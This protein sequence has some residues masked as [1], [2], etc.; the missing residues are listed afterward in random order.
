MIVSRKC[1]LALLYSIS[2][3]RFALF[4]RDAELTCEFPLGSQ[5]IS[6]IVWEKEG[7]R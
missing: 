7:D 3:G 4:G 2:A 5:I 6:N 1:M